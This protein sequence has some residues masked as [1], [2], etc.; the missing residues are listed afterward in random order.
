MAFRRKAPPKRKPRKRV[1]RQ[2]QAYKPKQKKRFMRK[3]QPFVETKKARDSI[4]IDQVMNPLVLEEQPAPQYRS[5][6]HLQISP[7]DQFMFLSRGVGDDEI[8]GRDI[9]SKYLKQKIQIEL[10]A[11]VIPDT[12]IPNGNQNRPFCR[13]TQPCPI[14]VVWGWIKQ[15]FGVR[16]SD[17]PT[18]NVALTVQNVMDQVDK[19]TN[20]G[21]E[22]LGNLNTRG[23]YESDFLTFKD[24]RK[25][26]WTMN[27]RLLR[28]RSAPTSVKPPDGY[29]T[30]RF[31]NSA[32]GGGAAQSE[33]NV[34]SDFGD[35]QTNGF[36][37]MLEATVSWRTNRKMRYHANT[38][39]SESGGFAKDSWIPYSYICIP[40]AYQDSVN[41]ASKATYRYPVDMTSPATHTYYDLVGDVKVSATMCHWFS[42]S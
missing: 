37:N 40:K 32:P 10:P 7:I 20:N 11:G 8:I 28:P 17:W 15:P 18:N 19:I 14:Y 42:D 35:Y 33:Q 23:T 38:P 39:T 16:N 21:D 30:N 27:K 3:R 2:K 34:I 6:R 5:F 31:V 25:N 41:R 12:T 1:F 24:K 36:P 13:I 4:Y 22:L 26:M 29:I 9:Y